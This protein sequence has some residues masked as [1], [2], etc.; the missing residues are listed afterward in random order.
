MVEEERRNATCITIANYIF[1][2]NWLAAITQ[3][4]SLNFF[5]ERTSLILIEIHN[6]TSISCALSPHILLSYSLGES[7]ARGGA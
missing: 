4:I 5:S 7:G 3:K 6:I 1:S 2:I